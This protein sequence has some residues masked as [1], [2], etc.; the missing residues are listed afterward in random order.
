MGV[1]LCGCVGMGAWLCVRMAYDIYILIIILTGIRGS[2]LM[3][4]NLLMEA[5]LER[6]LYSSLRER[7][8][9]SVGFFFFFW[10]G[11]CVCWDSRGGCV[12]VLGACWDFGGVC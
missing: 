6:V 8:R 2:V 3:E 7:E 12:G 4:S 5:C 1:W 11:G 10:G 9:E